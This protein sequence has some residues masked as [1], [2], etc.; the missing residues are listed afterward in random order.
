MQLRKGAV[1]NPAFEKTRWNVADVT[2]VAKFLLAKRCILKFANFGLIH[3]LRKSVSASS[4][5]SFSSSQMFR[6]PPLGGRGTSNLNMPRSR[7]D[8]SP[9][10]GVVEFDTVL[11]LDCTLGSTCT[12]NNKHSCSTASIM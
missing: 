11:E 6:V 9:G 12:G 5:G 1:S 10:T 7:F 3:S 8:L 4:M 2:V